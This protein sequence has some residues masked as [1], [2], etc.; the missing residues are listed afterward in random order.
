MPT[1]K[2]SIFMV[3]AFY[4]IAKKTKRFSL[5]L[6]MIAPLRRRRPL[7][8][9]LSSGLAI[10]CQLFHSDLGLVG[11]EEVE[12]AFIFLFGFIKSARQAQM[13]GI[14]SV[15][16]RRL[17]IPTQDLLKDGFSLVKLFQSIERLA[18]S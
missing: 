1:C 15:H 10:L 2:A 11:P 3:R 18:Q 16:R 12:R 14:A 4:V 17:R 13:R 8:Q 6:E 7:A 5:L 9:S